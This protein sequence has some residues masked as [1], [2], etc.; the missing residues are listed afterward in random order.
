MKLRI[1]GNSLR[2]RLSQSEVARVA[3]GQRVEERI[4]FSADAALVYSLEAADSVASVSAGYSE[5]RIAVIVPAA[6]ARVWADSGDVGLY[7][8][9][10]LKIAVE[11]DFRCTTEADNPPDAYPNPV[12]A[13]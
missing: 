4:E 6:D 3:A 5:Q 13:C 1:W 11:K 12:K 7:S 8:D 10:P 9:S 2:L